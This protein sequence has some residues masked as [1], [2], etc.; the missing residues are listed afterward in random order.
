MSLFALVTGPAVMAHSDFVTMG[1]TV[2]IGIKLAAWS[3][4]GG[5]LGLFFE[6]GDFLLEGLDDFCEFALLGCICRMRRRQG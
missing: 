4:R 3:R 6:F 1:P 5:L 2:S